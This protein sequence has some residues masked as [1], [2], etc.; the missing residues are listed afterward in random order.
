MTD[1]VTSG[2]FKNWTKDDLDREIERYRGYLD[3]GLD[4]NKAARRY[5]VPTEG[6][7]DQLDRLSWARA[8]LP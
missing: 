4:I 6:Y 7:A 1:R 2:Q 5:V 3:R 8:T